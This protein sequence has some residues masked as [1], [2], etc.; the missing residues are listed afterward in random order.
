MG[1]SARF[2]TPTPQSSAVNSELDLVVQFGSV[3][4]WRNSSRFLD[5][6]WID[7]HIEQALEI[8]ISQESK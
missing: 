4:K 3:T 1:N 6:A 7:R 5:V 8:T 2:G